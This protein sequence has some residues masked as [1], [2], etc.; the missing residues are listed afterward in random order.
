[1]R[2]LEFDCSGSASIPYGPEYPLF[3]FI[4]KIIWMYLT[5]II[6]NNSLYRVCNLPGAGR[7]ASSVTGD[8]YMK[9]VFGFEADDLT[10][11]YY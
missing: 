3:Y 2:G 4:C 9:A 7:G 5:L 8:E 10:Y 11:D 1:M 6:Y